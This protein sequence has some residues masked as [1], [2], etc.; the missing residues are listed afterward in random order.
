MAQR[1]VDWGAGLGRRR[2]AAVRGGLRALCR[3]PAAQRGVL[4]LSTTT[5][6]AAVVAALKIV[7]SV[8]TRVRRHTQPAAAALLASS[9]FGDF[10]ASASRKSRFPTQQSLQC[11]TLCLDFVAIEVFA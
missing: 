7:A 8:H 2:A 4:V 3:E 6:T 11:S 1:L 10:A 5:G 9:P